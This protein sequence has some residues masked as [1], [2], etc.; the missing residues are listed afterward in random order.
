[1]QR[2]EFLKTSCSLCI[3]ASTGLA[4]STLASCAPVNIYKAVITEHKIN[5]PVSL[6]IKNN[7][8]LIRAKNAEFDIALKKETDGTYTALLLKCTHADF[9]LT[10]TG[11]GFLCALHGSNFDSKGIVKKGPAELALKKYVTHLEEDSIVITL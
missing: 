6:F 1:M 7:L 9:G 3:L 10:A 2:K 8:Q 11:N 4:L 5:V